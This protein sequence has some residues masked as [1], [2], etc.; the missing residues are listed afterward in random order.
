MA[1]NFYLHI[2]SD[3]SPIELCWSKF[4]ELLRSAKA[5]TLD[6][7]DIAITNAINCISDEDALNWF[8]HCGLFSESIK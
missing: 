3:L 7:L 1:L 6:A 4:K 5:R 8:H 2:K